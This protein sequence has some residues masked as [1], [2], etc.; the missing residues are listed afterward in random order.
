MRMNEQEMAKQKNMTAAVREFSRIPP[1]LNLFSNIVKLQY[2]KCVHKICLYSEMLYFF[3]PSFRCSNDSVELDH[4]DV[5]DHVEHL[6]V[7]E[8]NIVRIIYVVKT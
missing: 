8:F 5:E 4:L 1:N 3:L 7:D 2:A 6:K